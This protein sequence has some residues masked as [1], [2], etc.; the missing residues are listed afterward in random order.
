MRAFLSLIAAC[1]VFS[2]CHKKEQKHT[3]VPGRLIVG[4]AYGT[5]IDSAFSFANRHGLYLLSANLYT[6]YSGLPKDSLASVSYELLQTKAYINKPT[7]DTVVDGMPYNVAGWSTVTYDSINGK[8]KVSCTLTN[9]DIAA[10][11]DWI[12]TMQRLQLTD[13]TKGTKWIY[14]KVTPGMEEL[15]IIKLKSDPLVSFVEVNGIGSMTL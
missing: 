10:Q 9:M 6:Y 13:V 8:I 1:L 5:P 4:M 7:P 12:S 14:V 2:A 15:E 3:F 11:S